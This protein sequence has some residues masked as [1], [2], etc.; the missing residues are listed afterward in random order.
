MKIKEISV[1]L[2][3]KSREFEA[4]SAIASR[5]AL[6]LE[7]V[8]EAEFLGVRT[9]L[10]MVEMLMM[11]TRN[12]SAKNSIEHPARRSCSLEM[13]TPRI[14]TDLLIKMV[15]LTKKYYAFDRLHFVSLIL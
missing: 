2:W 12:P 5:V 7:R 1:Y 13:D 6:L 14:C 9:L 4:R 8:V 15:I 3:R 11:R 10:I